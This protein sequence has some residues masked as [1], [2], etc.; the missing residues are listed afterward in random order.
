MI[1]SLVGPI[2]SLGMSENYYIKDNS[3]NTDGPY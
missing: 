2:I 3:N 1:T